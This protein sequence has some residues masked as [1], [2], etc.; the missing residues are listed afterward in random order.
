MALAN[1]DLKFGGDKKSKNF[2][3][4]IDSE[5]NLGYTSKV[6]A[7]RGWRNW[8]TRR[9]KD[10]VTALGREGSSPSLRIS[11]SARAGFLFFLKK[12][13][14]FTWRGASFFY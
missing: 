3:K 11:K 9:T 2:Q 14:D 10:P 8:Q 5:S 6:I 1:L 12:V 4:K 7:T 13:N